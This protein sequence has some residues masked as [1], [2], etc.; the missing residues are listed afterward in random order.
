MIPSL[1]LP[2]LLVGG[3]WLDTSGPTRKSG[4]SIIQS[5]MSIQESRKGSA[6]FP[7]VAATRDFLF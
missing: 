2:F 5:H 3:A 7:E 1:A 6:L 4:P